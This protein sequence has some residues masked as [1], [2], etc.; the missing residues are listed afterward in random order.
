[1]KLQSKNKLIRKAIEIDREQ[2]KVE[3]RKEPGAHRAE[4]A[5]DGKAGEAG[6]PSQDPALDG[7]KVE[8]SPPSQSSYEYGSES[9]YD[10]EE[11]KEVE[12]TGQRGEQPRS[13]REAPGSM[14]QTS[15][16]SSD[17]NASSSE[18]KSERS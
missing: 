10:E 1:M 16:A 18:S 6:L 8:E 7:Q 11:E 9:Y 14:S 12:A 2:V 5:V 4:K 17:A 15:I 13:R 3:V